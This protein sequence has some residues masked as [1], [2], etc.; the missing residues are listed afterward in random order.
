MN[1]REVYLGRM[2]EKKLGWHLT[3]GRGGGDD[4]RSEGFLL[5][6]WSVQFKR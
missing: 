2:R 3:C 1:S 4:F 5:M 6:R